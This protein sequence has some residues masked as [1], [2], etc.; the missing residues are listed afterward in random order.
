MS[1]GPVRDF[2]GDSAEDTVPDAVDVPTDASVEDP[3]DNPVYDTDQHESDE[4]SSGDDTDGT[5]DP[6]TAD[7]FDKTPGRANADESTQ[8]SETTPGSIDDTQPQQADPGQQTDPEQQSNTGSIDDSAANRIRALLQDAAEVPEVDENLVRLFYDYQIE[9]GPNVCYEW[10]LLPD[11]GSGKKPDWDQL[12][13][14]VAIMSIRIDRDYFGKIPLTA[15]RFKEIV[16]RFLTGV[17]IKHRS[18]VYLDFS[19]GEYTATG[20]DVT[21]STYYRLTSLSKAGEGIYTA[22]FDGFSFR[23]PDDFSSPY[24]AVSDNMKA[25]MDYCGE[26]SADAGFRHILGEVLKRPDYAEIL[27]R[28]QQPEITFELTDDPRYAFRYLSCKRIYMY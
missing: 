5:D 13:Q 6:D 22:T 4:T 21:G 11:F 10:R 12:T 17:E 8:D 19:N 7:K 2:A 1:G 28:D 16:E 20:W 25:L 3:A 15:Q 14:F 27:K 9:S 18:S 26:G 23:E 24:T